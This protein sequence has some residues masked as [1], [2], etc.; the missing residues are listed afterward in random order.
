M[1]KTKDFRAEI[2]SAFIK[3]LEENPKKWKKEWQGLG[4]APMNGNTGRNYNGLNRLWL[5]YQMSE[6]GWIDPRFYTFKQ[7]S[8]MGL[9]VQKGSKAVKVE[10]WSFYDPKEKKKIS[11]EEARKMQLEGKEIYPLAR[12][13]NIFNG[14]QIEGLPKYEQ[15][16]ISE[17]TQTTVINTISKNMN[18]PIVHDGGDR[19]FYS[20]RDDKVHLPIPEAFI[21]QAAYNG[22]ALH[23]LAHATGAPKRLNRQYGD[24][25]GDENY[26]KEELVAE[27]ASCFSEVDLG[28]T[29]DTEHFENHTAY[30]RTWIEKI[31]EKPE[32][33]MEA[34]KK[35]DT[36]ADYLVQSADL[37]KVLSIGDK[38]LNTKNPLWYGANCKQHSRGR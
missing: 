23:E 14:D 12:Y 11:Y 5:Q 10:F 33:L 30:V 16:K 21:S 27:I 20:I 18:V 9:R 38:I 32:S 37:D 36:A 2:A 4:N 31:R 7:I 35:A 17:A 24:F 26:A 3:S 19:A 22:T 29:G 1:N 34:I 6:H 28:I 13:Y 8:D 25:F 15:K